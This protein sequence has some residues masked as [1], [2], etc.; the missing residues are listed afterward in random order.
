M[1]KLLNGNMVDVQDGLNIYTYYLNYDAVFC[2]EENHATKIEI[3]ADNED[4]AYKRVCAL[5]GYSFE[6]AQ[7]LRLE[8][9]RPYT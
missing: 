8:D 9:V 6:A 7:S 4:N 5:L 3:V 2:C 1:R